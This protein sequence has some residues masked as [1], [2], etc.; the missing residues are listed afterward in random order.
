[1]CSVTGVDLHEPYV[2][3]ATSLTER[4]GLSDR[5]TFARAS[6]TALP[7]PAECVDVAW[8]QHAAMNIADRGSLYSE[9]A[10]VLVPGGRF[11][12]YD[13]LAGD[14]TPLEFPVPW[15]RDPG[16][17]TLVNEAQQRV[18][19]AQSGLDV[20]SWTDLTA[21]GIRWIGERSA[22]SKRHDADSPAL[23]LVLVM[24]ADFPSLVAMLGRNL[25]EGRARLVQAVARRE[26]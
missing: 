20:V 15:A 8:T 19:L 16:M 21:E 12:L 24:G 9:I 14:G 11:A 4:T 26:S 13:V 22:A 1:G 5:V 25:R 6:A 7:F 23:G 10:R 2:A 3:L 18:L 17:S